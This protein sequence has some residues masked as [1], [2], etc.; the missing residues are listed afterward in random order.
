MFLFSQHYFLYHYYLCIFKFFTTIFYSY[1][2][3]F[4]KYCLK[5]FSRDDLP[6]IGLWTQGPRFIFHHIL[7][8][9]LVT[10]VLNVVWHEFTRF[11]WV[12]LT[13]RIVHTEFTYIS[14]FI[15]LCCKTC[16]FYLYFM[17]IYLINIRCPSS[18][19]RENNT[20][21]MNNYDVHRKCRQ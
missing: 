10:R 11:L 21:R 16:I 15:Q 6:S 4:K 1:I 17:Y 14:I 12:Y 19:P 7:N 18:C 8:I 5:Y 2:W 20:S 3:F 13:V 9:V